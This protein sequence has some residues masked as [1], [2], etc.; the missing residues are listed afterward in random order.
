M[1]PV[2]PFFI[3]AL[4]AT[5]TIAL[6]KSME[7]L[8]DDTHIEKSKLSPILVAGM[9][10]S[11]LVMALTNSIVHFGLVVPLVASI[12][13]F[14][15]YRIFIRTDLTKLYRYALTFGL[16]TLL[17]TMLV[18]AQHFTVRSLS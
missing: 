10:W 8:P 15:I 16:V 13:L 6:S 17:S 9:G 4:M 1:K 18:A 12:C 7:T 11:A 2:I 5:L 14:V 3:V